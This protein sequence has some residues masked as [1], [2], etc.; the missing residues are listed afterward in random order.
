MK[1][2]LYDILLKFDVDEAYEAHASIDHK[3]ILISTPGDKF[4]NFKDDKFL[5][6]FFKDDTFKYHSSEKVNTRIRVFSN[7]NSELF[8]DYYAHLNWKEYFIL[9]WR[10]K[11]FWLL[12]K[13]SIM[14]I[15]NLLVAI[16]SI[17]FST[18]VALRLLSNG[19]PQKVELTNQIMLNEKQFD[20]LFHKLKQDK[21]LSLDSLQLNKLL[22]EF[23]KNDQVKV[24]INKKQLDEIIKSITTTK[25]ENK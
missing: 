13:D 6:D 25:E 1:F 12:Q 8:N 15:I 2:I 17:L 3:F 14:W 20:S 16:I 23:Q 5:F 9:A 21:L 18:Y 10:F 4:R 24:L 19:T 7:D 11:K 22:L